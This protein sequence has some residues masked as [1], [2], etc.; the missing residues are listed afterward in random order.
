M[1]LVKNPKAL[2]PKPRYLVCDFAACHYSVDCE[3]P[4]VLYAVLVM[5]RPGTTSKMK[6]EVPESQCHEK[7]V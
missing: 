7:H 5:E 1:V 3:V 4:L 2:K 6:P